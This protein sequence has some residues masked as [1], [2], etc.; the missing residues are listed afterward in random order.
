VLDDAVVGI[1][2]QYP[3]LA[4]HPYPDDFVRHATTPDG[5]T[6]IL[7]AVRAED[8]PFWHELVASSS[9]ESIRFRFRSLLKRTTH[10]MAVAQC[11]I[12]YERQISIVAETEARGK[13]ELAGIAHLLADANH[14]TAEFAVLVP[15]PWQGRKI[16]GMLLD[17]CMELAGSWGIKK[18]VAETAPQNTRM[19]DTFKSRGFRYEVHLDDDVVLLER[20]V[21]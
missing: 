2:H 18:I 6:I 15:D 20:D 11:V 9:E 21:E 19:L 3:H 17:Y 14:D 1:V 4:I 10:Q 12:D 7:R 5:A 13:K 16:G 8:E